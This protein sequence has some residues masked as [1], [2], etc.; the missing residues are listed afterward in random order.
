MKVPRDVS[1]NDLLKAI[2]RIGYVRVR[3]KGSHVYC[4]TQ[5]P[6]EHHI[7]IPLHDSLKVGTLNSILRELAAHRNQTRDELLADLGI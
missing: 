7:A 6:S 3:Q 5:F 2:V 1:G 4:T